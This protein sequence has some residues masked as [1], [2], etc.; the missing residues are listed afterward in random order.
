MRDR[1]EIETDREREEERR[2]RVNYVMSF[3]TTKLHRHTFGICRDKQVQHIMVT[4]HVS[5]ELL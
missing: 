2:E 1:G 5:D 4:V 3:D